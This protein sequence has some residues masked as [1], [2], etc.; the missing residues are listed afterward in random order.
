MWSGGNE[1]L[2]YWAFEKN[3]V[4]L[5]IQIEIFRFAQYDKVDKSRNEG[6]KSKL[7]GENAKSKKYRDKRDSARIC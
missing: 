3:E 7:R 6:V 2:S 1:V 5:K 4:S